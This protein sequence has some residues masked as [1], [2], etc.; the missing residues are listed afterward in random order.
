AE[1][2]LLFG[3]MPLFESLIYITMFKRVT[4]NFLKIIAVLFLWIILAFSFS[5]FIMFKGN[6][7]P[8]GDNSFTTFFNALLKTV[9]MSTGEMDYTDMHFD[10]SAYPVSSR[11]VFTLFIFVIVFVTMNLINGIAISDIK[12][13]LE[14]AENHAIMAEAE[15]IIGINETLKVLKKVIG[16]EYL[17]RLWNTCL[18][19]NNCFPTK[20]VSLFPNRHYNHIWATCEGHPCSI[21]NINHCP[22]YFWLHI[23]QLYSLYYNIFI[24]MWFLKKCDDCKIYYDKRIVCKESAHDCTKKYE[25]AICKRFIYRRNESSNKIHYCLHRHRYYIKNMSIK[26]IKMIVEKQRQ[27]A[28]SNLRNKEVKIK[29]IRIEHL[30]TCINKLKQSMDEEKQNIK[31]LQITVNELSET[32]RKKCKSE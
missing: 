31:N 17:N 24:Q 16:T 29:K 18:V 7:L 8:E 3:K 1:I 5:F 19:F 30:Q 32:I 22:Y 28:D 21:S 10:L 11:L 12:D 20:K 2:I 9:V 27:E 26:A 14:E 25:C 6:T 4:F 15:C 23:D 13:I